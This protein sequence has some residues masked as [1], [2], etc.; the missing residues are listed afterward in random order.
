MLYNIKTGYN[1][2]P[3]RPMRDIAI[4]VTSLRKIADDSLPFVFT[5]RH[6][7]LAAARFSSDLKELN[8][9][10][11]KTLGQRDFKRDPNKP[12]KVERYQAEAL[13]HGAV[14]PSSLL[15]IACYDEARA[16]EVNAECA[17]CSI[18][19]RVVVRPGWFF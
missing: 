5:D 2:I 14:P 8:H 16:Q 4:L 9:V 12:E 10:D 11:W 6:A 18:S 15:G 7:N 19:I 17:R 13:I 3:Q 1:G